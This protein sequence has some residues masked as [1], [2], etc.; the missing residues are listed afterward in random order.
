MVSQGRKGRKKKSQLIVYKL[1]SNKIG[2]RIRNNEYI[3]Y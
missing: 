3:I 1:N 2:K